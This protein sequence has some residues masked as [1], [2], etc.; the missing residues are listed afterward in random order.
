MP[1]SSLAESRIKKLNGVSLTLA[2]VNWIARVADGIPEG[3]VENSWAVAIASFKK[4]YVVKGGKWM[5]RK[6]GDVAKMLLQANRKER[7]Q[8]QGVGGPRQGDAGTD[9]CVCPECGHTSSHKRGTPCADITCPECGA[10][11]QG[12]NTAS[13]EKKDDGRY[14]II[15]ISTAALE[16]KEGET[17]SIGAIDYDIAQANKLGDYPEFRVFHQP[18]L[19]IGMVEKMRRVGI[20]AVDEGTSYDDPFSIDVCEKMLRDNDDGIWKVSRGFKVY[21]ASGFCPTCGEGLVFSLKHMVAGFRCPSCGEVYLGYKRT[22][23]DVHFRKARTFDVTVTD[24]PAVPWTSAAAFR[25]GDVKEISMTK[26]QLREKLV[27]AGVDED[28]I[29]ARLKT[30]NAKQLKEFDDIPDAILLK[31]L[32]L[33]DDDDGDGDEEL[34]IV[35]DDETLKAFSK[36][37]KKELA[38]ALEGLTIEVPDMEMEL[39]ELP[40]V[41]E[42][43]QEVKG[44]KELVAELLEKDDTRLKSMLN[45]M[46]RAGRLRI[47]RYK[48]EPE[49]DEE[50]EEDE[51]E[52]GTFPFKKKK[53][54]LSGDR[55]QS[56]TGEVFSSMTEAV[57]QNAGGE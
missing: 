53:K 39:K 31:E 18:G 6:K 55:I 24:V 56:G 21:E 14:R 51:E 25:L 19:A 49:E 47:K 42:L 8:D 35:L 34:T 27:A 1:Y 50:D 36:I 54:S 52:E 3:E 16:D 43:V 2:Q 26:K 7:G 17:F 29:D 37:V 9:A 23:K 38:E 5:K 44:L 48:A 13:V 20:F 28:A 10:K 40:A 57:M 32:E 30:L 45:D 33:E 46:P 22:L 4:S 12:A 41:D 11:M 15:T